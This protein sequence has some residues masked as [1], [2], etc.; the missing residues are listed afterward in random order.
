MPACT[1]DSRSL[2]NQLHLISSNASI[3]DYAKEGCHYYDLLTK[4]HLL[5]VKNGIKKACYDSV[6][7]T[8]SEYFGTDSDVDSVIIKHWGNTGKTKLDILS[9]LKHISSKI[10]LRIHE[11]RQSYFYVNKNDAIPDNILDKF[12]KNR[13]YGRNVWLFDDPNVKNTIKDVVKGD[14]RIG[15]LL[16]YPKCCVDWFTQ[17]RTN[18]LIDCYY[19][20][21]NTPGLILD[22]D[23]V[24]S[25]L[26]KYFE[27][28]HVPN[29]EKR[30]L[31]IQRNH[32][33]KTVLKYPFVFHQACLTCL[34][35]LISPTAKL[36]KKYERFARLVSE[37]FYEKLI[38]ESKKAAD[39][40]S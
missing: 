30:I 35:N 38:D 28:N 22:D 11:E 20:C 13:G 15:D 24:T 32:V 21:L 4:L 3:T 5:L 29:N 9:H 36:N 26:L 33:G 2:Q 31:N 37:E 23:G 39:T 12:C 17:T 7:L 8:T 25:F 16:G 34:K 1:N 27:T 18:S 6:S 14:I 19:L 10:N 40:Y